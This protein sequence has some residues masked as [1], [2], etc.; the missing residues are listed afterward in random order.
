[1]KLKVLRFFGTGK[2]SPVWLRK[3]CLKIVINEI[4][5]LVAQ[6]N[7]GISRIDA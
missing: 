5:R 3:I 7:T 4:S 2:Y 6:I 1:M